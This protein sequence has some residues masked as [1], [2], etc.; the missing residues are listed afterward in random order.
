MTHTRHLLP[1][2][3]LASLASLAAGASLAAC[4]SADATPTPGTAQRAQ[5]TTANTDRDLCVALLQRARTCTDQYIPTLVDARAAADHPA[6]I[7]EE[8]AKDRAGV[9]AQA[10][11]EWATDSTDTNIAAV[12]ARPYLQAEDQ[13]E[14]ATRCQAMSACGEFAACLVP[15]EQAA[16]R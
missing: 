16:W 13:R 11:Q 2:M 7:K 4:A 5:A 6:G 10:N 15:I 3:M 8:V 14:A 9:I 1:F 12:C